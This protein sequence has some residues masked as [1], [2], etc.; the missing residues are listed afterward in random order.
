MSNEMLSTIELDRILKHAKVTRVKYLGAYPSCITPKTKRR[1]YSFISNTDEHHEIGEHWC[2]WVVD[3]EKI[4][5]FDSFGRDPWDT[6]LPTH[7]KDIV[8]GYNHVEYT[9]V[10]VQDW[11]STTC[12]HFCI[13]FIYT[14][15]LGLSYENFLN[16][17]STDFLNNDLVALD[18][19]NSIIY[20]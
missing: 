10:R 15:S 14:L 17:Y 20:P 9:N 6:S 7:F 3:G 12:G 13:H 5:F 4:Y 1:N 16:E 11:T 2:A 18:F 19:Y 8:R